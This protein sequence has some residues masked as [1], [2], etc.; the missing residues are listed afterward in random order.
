MT[1]QRITGIFEGTVAELDPQGRWIVVTRQA[2]PPNKSKPVASKFV[3]DPHVAVTTR[4]RG[5]LKLADLKPDQKVTVNYGIEPV[6]KRVAHTIT[7][8]EPMA[9]PAAS[10]FGVQVAG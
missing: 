6:G 3:L 4:S 10:S 7:L 5:T 8:L 9:Q 2:S 1:V